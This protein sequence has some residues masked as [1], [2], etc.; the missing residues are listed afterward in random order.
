[1]PNTTYVAWRLLPGSE[2]SIPKL[3][4]RVRLMV[5][6]RYHHGQTSAG[7]FAPVLEA[8]EAA[9]RVCRPGFAPTLRSCGGVITRLCSGSRISIFRSSASAVCPTGTT[10]CRWESV[11]SA[12]R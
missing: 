12:S 10:I 1:M 7:E 8:E 2:Q 3:S 11:R 9:L 6:D 4:L 5:N